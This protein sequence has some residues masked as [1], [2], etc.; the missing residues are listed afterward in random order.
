MTTEEWM[1]RL[2][3]ELEVLIADAPDNWCRAFGEALLQQTY[4]TDDQPEDA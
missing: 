1:G 3:T 2:Q 4:E